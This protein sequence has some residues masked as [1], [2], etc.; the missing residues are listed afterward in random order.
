LSNSNSSI[1][2]LADAGE[3]WQLLSNVQIK[4]CRKIKGPADGKALSSRKPEKCD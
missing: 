4:L 3:L 1:R 2:R